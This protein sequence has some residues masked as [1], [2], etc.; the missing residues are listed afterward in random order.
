LGICT[1]DELITGAVK[2]DEDLF[3]V[4]TGWVVGRLG[5]LAGDRQYWRFRS[6]R[7]SFILEMEIGKS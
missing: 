5:N 7:H 3:D 1:G 2:E 6:R 4:G